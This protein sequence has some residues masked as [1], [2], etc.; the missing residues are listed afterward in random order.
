MRS[1]ERTGSVRG[2]SDVEGPDDRVRL[3]LDL[4]RGAEPITGTVGVPGRAPQPFVGWIDLV[5]LLE[6]AVSAGAPRATAEESR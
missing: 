1:R 4:L 3:M 6:E 2:V 5:A